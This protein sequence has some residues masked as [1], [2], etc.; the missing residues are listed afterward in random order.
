MISGVSVFLTT[1]HFDRLDKALIRPGRV[2]VAVELGNASSAMLRT[3]FLRFYPDAAAAIDRV[4][5]A[6][7][8]KSL[9]PARIQQALLESDDVGQA[10][11]LLG[12][13]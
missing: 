12:L 8:D 7:E 3:M 4:L 10:L 13:A 2:D 5:A 1:N 6:Y 11:R 9:S